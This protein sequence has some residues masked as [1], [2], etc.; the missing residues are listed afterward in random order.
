[1]QKKK[2]GKMQCETS[3]ETAAIG[4]RN[5]LKTMSFGQKYTKTKQERK[6]GRILELRT[7]LGAVPRMSKSQSEEPPNPRQK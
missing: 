7:R 3:I 4:V 6:V 2:K 5:I 1:M